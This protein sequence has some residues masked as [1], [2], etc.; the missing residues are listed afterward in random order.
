MPELTQPPFR[1]R[2]SKTAGHRVCRK[3]VARLMRACGLQARRRRRCA[4]TID[5]AHAFSLADN[6]VARQLAVG[7]PVNTV[8][9][10]DTTFIPTG[11][12]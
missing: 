1:S 2:H 11:E 9:V 5:S 3:R 7:G 4:V 12:G 10:S 8:W 6:V